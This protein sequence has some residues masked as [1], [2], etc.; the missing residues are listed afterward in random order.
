V[1]AK[2]VAKAMID[3]DF[4]R[5]I[6]SNGVDFKGLCIDLRRKLDRVTAE[7]DAALGREA[8]L[9]DDVQTLG[10]IVDSM[11]VERDA[12]QQRLTAADERA[13]RMEG[14]LKSGS[15]PTYAHC[16]AVMEALKP[17]EGG[18]DA[19]PQGCCCPPKGHTGLW[20]A[21]MCPVHQGLRA[22]KR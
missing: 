5:W 17:A 8:A 16:E 18:G 15:S 14:L 19:R 9:K 7:R 6:M 3:N 11:G 13:D 12:L 2:N 20:A 21:G 4:L 22:L 1:K 10:C